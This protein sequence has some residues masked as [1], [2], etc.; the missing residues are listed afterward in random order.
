MK[1]RKLDAKGKGA[2]SYDYANDVLL[3]KIKDRTY[4]QSVEFE[5]FVVDIDDKGFIT[6][7]Q[8]FDASKL[9]RID[10]YALR[11]V[12]HFDFQA[13]LDKNVVTVQLRFSCVMRNKEIVKQ[14][15]DFHWQTQELATAQS[16]LSSAT[17]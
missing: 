14:G 5:N 13:R 12:N 8:V 6:G 16:T 3:F 15:Q 9:L 10:K 2:Y 11:N 4:A 7:I 17:A 1:N